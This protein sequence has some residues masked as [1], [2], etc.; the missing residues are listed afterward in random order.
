MLWGGNKRMRSKGVRTMAERR[1]KRMRMRRDE[2]Q[3]ESYLHAE[4]A[5]MN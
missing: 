5:Y 4:A 2:V 3:R 1:R